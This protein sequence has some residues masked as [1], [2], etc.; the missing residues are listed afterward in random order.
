MIPGLGRSPGGRHGS[1]LQ[2]SCLENLRDRGAWQAMVHRVTKTWAQLKRFST[3]DKHRF[4]GDLSPH[5]HKH[6]LP[7]WWRGK[8]FA[9][10]CRRCGFH[11]WVGKIPW[12]R[13]WPPAPVF[14]PGKF[15]GLR[16]LAGYN[17]WVCKE[18]G[19]TEWLSMHTHAHKLWGKEGKPEIHEILQARI[20]EWLAIPCSRR[21]LR[22]RDWAH[23]SCTVGRFFTIWVTR[24]IHK[25]D[26]CRQ[27]SFQ[28]VALGPAASTP[29]RN[30]I[31]LQYLVHTDTYWIGH[32]RMDLVICSLTIPPNTS[33]WEPVVQVTS[34][35]YSQRGLCKIFPTLLPS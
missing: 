7:R 26:R 13:K 22:P 2:Y 8:E 9:C 28:S 31:E 34:S 35:Q 19:V 4:Y 23:V 10:Q 20:L 14:L 16:S 27:I 5:K 33:N 30:F 17:S 21:S 6:R 24:G 25:R 12:S 15:H 18:L 3:H 29:L 1:P 11:P 32:S